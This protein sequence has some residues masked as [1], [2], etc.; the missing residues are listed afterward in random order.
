MDSS[1]IVFTKQGKTFD[2]RIMTVLKC[3]IRKRWFPPKIHGQMGQS[4]Q[5]TDRPPPMYDIIMFCQKEDAI[6]THL[7]MQN[8]EWDK[9]PKY[10][11]AKKV[12]SYLSLLIGV[13]ERLT[14][15]TLHVL[16]GR[17]RRIDGSG[18]WSRVLTEVCQHV[19]KVSKAADSFKISMSKVLV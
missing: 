14:L 19:R 13:K 16:V 17:L 2:S 9:P 3:T 5:I 11:W 7:K 12:D 1:Q 10:I 4:R 15:S 8:V 18:Y 6:L